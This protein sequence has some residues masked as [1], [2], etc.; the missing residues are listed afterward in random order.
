ML[1]DID[2]LQRNFT[3]AQA[4]HNC[5]CWWIASLAGST[6]IER[7]ATGGGAG[8]TTTGGNGGSGGGGVGIFSGA[9]GSSTSPRCNG[10]ISAIMELLDQ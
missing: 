2:R 4:I 6:S 7:I 1:V 3:L 5:W 9:G 8:G 10:A